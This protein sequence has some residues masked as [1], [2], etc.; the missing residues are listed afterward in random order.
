MV[1]L[2]LIR[3]LE[4]YFHHRWLYL[5]PILLMMGIATAYIFLQ[6]PLYLAGGVLHVQTDNLINTLTVGSNT[7]FSWATP[8]EQKTREISDLL[9]TDAFVRAII[10]ETDL[11][12]QMSGGPD[13]ISSI[14]DDVRK[15]VWVTPAGDNQL[16]VAASYED[17][18][19]TYQLVTAL[20]D[21]YV[22]WQINVELTESANAQKFFADLAQE[23][24]SDLEIARQEFDNYLLTHTEPERGTRPQIEQIQISRL[25]G[26]VN[27]ASE[28]YASSIDKEETARLAIIQAESTIQQSYF[29]IDAPKVPTSAEVSRKSQVVTAAIFVIIGVIISGIAIVGNAL[30]DRSFRVPLDINQILNLPVLAAVPDVNKALAKDQ[31]DEVG[32]KETSSGT[33]GNDKKKGKLT[34]P[35]PVS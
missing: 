13:V 20:V 28:R 18:N 10:S 32:E 8:A 24:K 6:T 34:G 35:Q 3:L 25:E 2:I 1:R 29:L 15:A 16:L 11:E 14:I 27:L 12:S 5:L 9:S 26:E 23:Y 21:T 33:K 4:S 31:T 19:I 17:P 30:L 7:N 22:N